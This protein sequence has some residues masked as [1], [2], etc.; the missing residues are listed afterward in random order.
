M[1]GDNDPSPGEV[2]ERIG[3]AYT[4]RVRLDD[5]SVL[6]CYLSRSY[7]GC[8]VR[9]PEKRVPKVG[10]KVLVMRTTIESDSGQ[11]VRNRRGGI[12]VKR[13]R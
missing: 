6:V 2:V 9:E 4:W 11:I 1:W 10:E 12:T 7:I 5:G 8:R 3:Q 13:F